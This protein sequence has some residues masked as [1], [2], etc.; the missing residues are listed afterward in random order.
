MY[1]QLFSLLA[2]AALSLIGLQA[3]AQTTPPAPAVAPVPSG[4]RCSNGER[5]PG[6]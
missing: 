1:R 2:V 6:L 3:V 4:R 5:P